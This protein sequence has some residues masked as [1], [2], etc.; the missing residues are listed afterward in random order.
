M[1]DVGQ[2]FSREKKAKQ[3]RSREIASHAA[4][5]VENEENGV[6]TEDEADYPDDAD[7]SGDEEDHNAWK[8]RELAR[9]MRDLSKV[10]ILD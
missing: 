3:Q 8:A 1:P 6:M 4:A 10:E 5:R 2:K 7:E 9:M